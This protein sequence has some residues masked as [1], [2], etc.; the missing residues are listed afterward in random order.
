MKLRGL[1]RRINEEKVMKIAVVGTGY[2]G[3][4]AGVCFADAGHEVTCIDNNEEKINM[5]LNNEVP[6]YEPGLR[7]VLLRSKSRL[8][9]STDIKEAISSYM[10]R[11]RRYGKIK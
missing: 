11:E 8:K 6:I 7:D 5:L 1:Y 3:L 10:N 2:V 4:V 9:F